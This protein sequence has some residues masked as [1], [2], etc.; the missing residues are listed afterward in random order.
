MRD[1]R[2]SRNYAHLL[3]FYRYGLAYWKT[4]LLAVFWMTAYSAAGVGAVLM[5]RP[6]IESFE[7]G[8]G[9]TAP[10]AAVAPAPG[11]EAP[12]GPAT[13]PG[14]GSSTRDRLK[15]WFLDLPVIRHVS[16]WLWADMSLKR[17]A[18]VLLCLIGPLF[19]VSG[20]FQEY[21]SGRVV[22]L[23][24][25]D[26][27]MAVFDRLSR[28]SLSFFS[29][30]RA[31]DLISRLTHDISRTE[32]ALKVIFSKILLQP[33][34]LTFFLA[35]AVWHSPHLTLVAGVLLPALV[36]VIGRY[37]AR[38]RRHATKMLEKLADVTDSVTQ[39]LSGIRVV[40]SF[41][42]EAAERD[43]FRARNRAQVRKA[44][45]LVR[46]EAWAGVLPHFLVGVLATSLLLLVADR[47]V[48]QGS[49]QLEEAAVCVIALGLVEGRMR[50]I[51]KAYNTL[52][53]S[54]ASVNRLFEIIDIEPEIQDSPEAVE[55]PS[56]GEGIDYRGVHFAYDQEP[57]LRGIDLFVPAGKTYAIVGETGAGKSTMLD[58]IPRF[59]DVRAGSVSIGGVDVREARRDSLMGL[60]AIVGQH[61]FL[62]NR[63]IAENIRY[64]RPQATDQEVRAAAQAANIDEFIRGLPSGYETL[65]GEAGDHF[66]GGQRQCITI[67][68]A[69]LKDAP[70]LILDE[71][72]SSLDAESEMLV[73]RALRTLMKGRTTL[74]IAHRLSTVRHADCIVVLKD[75]RIVEQGTH[76]ELLAARGE[77][78]RLCRLQFAS[79]DEA[80]PGP[81]AEARP[82]APARTGEGR[83]AGSHGPE[84]GQAR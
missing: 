17:I 14:W 76:E 46:S 5:V 6:L 48:R 51:V 15:E 73:Q 4:I 49:L 44:L 69:L 70:I 71:A 52:Q 77:Y 74:V 62:F 55:L 78:Y 66:S 60:I 32:S 7:A 18:I 39:M 84:G 27:R 65:A 82:A 67:A 11:A 37:G 26:V 30:R 47:L 19:L 79:V 83:S 28:L 20:F 40:K 38:I 56:V 34:M 29:R 58:M 24:L 72:T 1:R 50:R 81:D 41:H 3:R 53:R 22:W 43:E 10:V 33:L 23:V 42:M 12:A 57:V 80:A 16:A 64:G 68:R 21:L 25:A 36:F 2:P 54:M 61:P 13:V 8:T 45:K 35:I 75:G 63:S 31:G 59:Y 9:G